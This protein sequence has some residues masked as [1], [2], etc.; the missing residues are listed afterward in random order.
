M[1]RSAPG[2]VTGR[3]I[4]STSP[5]VGGCWGRRPAISRRIV[6]LPQPLG[7]RM[8]MNSPL[9]TRSST[10]NVTLRIAVNSLDRPGLYVLVTSRNSTTCGCRTSPRLLHAGRAPGRCRPPA[11]LGPVAAV[12]VFGFGLLMVCL[13]RGG[14]GRVLIRHD[15]ARSPREQRSRSP[16]AGLPRRAA[17]RGRA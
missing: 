13:D 15:A 17:R 1:P 3:P 4:T 7:P 6:L 8:Q 2:P 16:A 9:S 5:L 11:R 12:T 10:T 14:V